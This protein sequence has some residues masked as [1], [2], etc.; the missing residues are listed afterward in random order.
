MKDN[1]TEITLTKLSDKN[2][3]VAFDF[4]DDDDMDIDIRSSVDSNYMLLSNHTFDDVSKKKIL[5]T[6]GSNA[7]SIDGI[8]NNM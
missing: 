6:S 2:Q 4:N 1:N 5:S 7:E 8:E 3:V